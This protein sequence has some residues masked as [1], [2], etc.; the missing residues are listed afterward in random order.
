[1]SVHVSQFSV[2]VWAPNGDVPPPVVTPRVESFRF[3]GGTG[4]AYYIVP[5]LSD[6][7]Q[8]L[9]S[10]TIKAVR[11]TGRLT[12]ASAMVYGYDVG[13]AIIMAD[14][15]DGVRTDTHSVTRPQTFPDTTHVTQT[16]RKPVNV[17]NAV[18][19]TMRLEGDD[20]GNATRDRIEEIVYEVAIQGVR[21]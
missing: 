14:L 17:A 18:L 10:K 7:G 6:S 21:R 9:R 4:S 8:E 3:D 19:H 13:Q 11:V 15:E 12:S 5:Q 2:T 16:A 1:M 20:T